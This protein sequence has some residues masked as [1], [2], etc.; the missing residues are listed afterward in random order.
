VA[1]R[2]AASGITESW[3]V[4]LLLALGLGSLGLAIAWS[5]GDGAVATGDVRPRR[6]GRV[7]RTLGR[8]VGGEGLHA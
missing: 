1:A 3:W 7:S 5:M 8:R 4:L 2:R 6:Q